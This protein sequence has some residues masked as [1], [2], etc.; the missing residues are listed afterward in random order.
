MRRGFVDPED[1]SGS[2]TEADLAGSIMAGLT[3]R[4]A[5]D[6]AFTQEARYLEGNVR[7]LIG[8]RT[9]TLCFDGA[10]SVHVDTDENPS[11]ESHYELAGTLEDWLRVWSGAVLFAQALM[12]RGATIQVNGDVVRFTAESFVMARLVGLMAD[13]ARPSGQAND[14]G[15]ARGSA[16]VRRGDDHPHPVVGRYV[17]VRGVRT[18]YESYSA[19]EGGCAFLAVHTSGRDCRQWQDLGSVLSR[20]GSFFALDLPGH[21]KSWPVPHVGCLSSMDAIAEFVWLFWEKVGDGRPTVV[22]GTSVGG[23][24]AFQLAGDHSEDVSA[25]VSMQGC[26]FIPAM[27]AQGSLLLDHPRINPGYNWDRSLSLVGSR[28]PESVRDYVEW[29]VRT[30]TSVAGKAD[31]T[32]YGFDYRQRTRRIR[33]PSL[34][35]RGED[36]WIVT[37]DMVRESAARLTNAKEVKVIMPAGIGHFPHLEQPNEIACHVIDFLQDAE[38]LEPRYDGDRP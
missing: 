28:A 30:S 25:M 29:E 15:A 9:W 21:G 19:S 2:G 11:L 1:W 3:A 26:D 22:L 38:L 36:D 34:L 18:Y 6:D 8:D 10:G 35:I 23:N 16:S 13:M 31:L 17:D 14:H 24:L 37:A 32:A 27:S 33:C 12:G 7:L 4:C 20:R 5:N